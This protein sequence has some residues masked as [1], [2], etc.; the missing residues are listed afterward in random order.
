MINW[1]G[2]LNWSTKH[3]DG[4]SKTSI[5]KLTEEQRSWLEYVIKESTLDENKETKK[6]L[7]SLIQDSI[8]RKKF[9]KNKN[10]TQ[11]E[12][13]AEKHVFADEIETKK[14][15]FSKEG[16]GEKSLASEIDSLDIN[17]DSIRKNGDRMG[18][19]YN[20]NNNKNKPMLTLIPEFDIDS[21]LDRIEA[22]RN[23]LVSPDLAM[24]FAKM[25]GFVF[26]IDSATD[27]DTPLKVRE[28]MLSVVMEFSQNN[29][30]VQNSLANYKFERVLLNLFDPEATEKT[31]YRVLGALKGILVGPNI[32]LKRSF[33]DS[34][35]EVSD[36]ATPI[37][38]Q[39]FSASID[40]K[41]PDFKA[42]HTGQS[43]IISPF[44]ALLSISHAQIPAKC[45]RRALL[46][47]E[48]LYGYLP[49]LEKQIDTVED[50]HADP[51]LIPTHPDFQKFPLVL[52]RCQV[53]VL[54]L[55]EN[56]QKYYLENLSK[57]DEEYTQFSIFLNTYAAFMTHVGFDLKLKSRYMALGAIFKTLFRHLMKKNL[58]KTEKM[59]LGRISSK[60]NLL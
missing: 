60:F 4:T 6:I 18:V 46:L 27:P 37:K 13:E 3:H 2:F 50:K 57:V 55:L 16:K 33:L 41:H 20:Q 36:L 30:F 45:L 47:I 15:I 40:T 51:Q 7:D 34:H 24:N 26:F 38:K 54:A 10:L 17:I 31:L 42:T 35:L 49:F 28:A 19:D 23:L 12:A 8:N 39:F 59:L 32:H 9:S 14:N 58:Q 52:N 53:G 48:D 44:L 29:D 1:T 22:L 11:L 56:L 25:G 5:P 43:A 21:T